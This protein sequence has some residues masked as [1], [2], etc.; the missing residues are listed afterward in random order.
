MIPRRTSIKTFFLRNMIFLAVTSILLW[1][2]VWVYSELSAFHSEILSL[3][4]NYINSQKEVLKKE[5]TNLTRYINS[6]EQNKEIELKRIIKDRTHIAHNIARNIY[7]ENRGKPSHE[8][9]KMI[10]DSLRPIRFNNGRCY[11][12]M[13]SMDGVE[14]LYPIKPELEGVNLID[15][16]DSQ[17]TSVIQ[18]EINVIEKH[19]E[20]FVTSYWTKPYHDRTLQFPQITFVKH[21]E[22]LN[23]YVGTGDY[24]DDFE[25]TLKT[26]V[27]NTI[28]NLQLPSGGHLFGSTFAGEPLLSNGNY[29][30]SGEESNHL[31]VTK[32]TTVF[33]QLIDTAMT[34]NGG[35][36]TFSF[37][38]PDGSG[39]DPMISYVHGIPIWNWLIGAEISLAAIEDTISK[40]KDLLKNNITQ[41]ILRS[42]LILS[43]LFI[44]IY[45]WSRHVAHRLSKNIQ[46]FSS[47]LHNAS[48]IQPGFVN[49]DIELEEF[50]RIALSAQKILEGRNQAVKELY[51]R[52][53]ELQITLNATTD[54]IWTWNLKTN[55]LTF[56]DRYSDMLGYKPGELP[57]HYSDWITLTHPDDRE[58]VNAMV[59]NVINEEE[60]YENEFR[61]RTK[62]GK[63][64]WISAKAKVAERNSEGE[65]L[66]IIGNH[67]D[68][69][70]RKEIEEEANNQRV[71]FE[72][73]FNTIPDAVVITDTQRVIQLANNGLHSVFG[74]SEEQLIGKTTEQLYANK[75]SYKLAGHHLFNENS[76]NT[77]DLYITAYRSN[78]GRSFPGE[79]FGAKLYDND[80]KWIGNLGIIRDISDRVRLE[81]EKEAEHR[82]L[83]SIFDG[84]DEVIYVSD[85]VTYELLY[86]NSAFTSKF[87]KYLHK[88]CYRVLQ[89]REEP[90]P[91]CT[92]HLILQKNIGTTHIWEHYN[93]L[94]ERWYRCI[95]RAINWPDDRV[96]RF[97]MALD[98]TEQKTAQ[99]IVAKTKDHLES[100]W[101]I[102]Q[103]ADH[104]IATICDLVL[105]E[106]QKMGESK[107]AFYGFL[108][109]EETVMNLHAWSQEAYRGC[110]VADKTKHFPIGNAGIWAEAVRKRKIV[111]VNTMT[112]GHTEQQKTPEGHVL[113]TR[114]MAVPLEINNKIVAIAC[115]ANKSTEYTLDDGQQ[116]L[117]FLSN[118]QILIDRKKA[119]L[120]LLQVR[121]SLEDAQRVAKIGSWEWNLQEDTVW[122]SDELYRIYGIEKEDGFENLENIL[123]RNVHPE[124]KAYLKQKINNSLVTGRFSADYKITNNGLQELSAEGE[125]L[126]DDS[127]KPE[128][129]IGTV[130]N[131]TTEKEFE[132]KMTQAHKMEAMGTLAGGIAHDFNNILAVII[133]Y[134]QM[135][136][137]D[138]PRGSTYRKDIQQISLAADRAKDLVS[139][140]LAFSRQS[141]VE[142]LPIMIKPIV[143]EAVKMLR[144]SIPS[145]I[146][147]TQNIQPTSS[148]ILADP[149]QIHQILINLCTNAYHAMEKTGGTLTISLQ[150]TAISSSQAQLLKIEP[151]EYTEL[152][153]TDTGNG[154]APENIDKIFEP[155][156]TTKEMGKGT[157]MGLSIIH[158]IINE[159]GGT[160][161]VD[162]QLEKGSAFHV[163]FPEVQA[164]SMPEIAQ[165]EVLQ[166]G[167][168]H[169]L[170]IDD[171]ILLAEMGK[172]ILERLGYRVTVYS[173]SLEALS[174]FLNNPNEFDLVI[175]DQTMPDMTGSVLAGR[176]LQARPDIPII[177][178]TGYSN[179]IDEH[180]AKAI[181]IKEFTFK[182][183]AQK[184]L[185]KLI[186][187]V[188]D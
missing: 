140:I 160:I 15:L 188:L 33:H 67:E 148:T 30:I 16:E 180:S 117:S 129:H 167:R 122:L 73:I 172:V 83:I 173:N 184:V 38:K 44:G 49:S 176:M 141:Q 14:Q 10:K 95:D 32:D 8:I 77:D 174:A 43:L 58:S 96:V 105:Q 68:I 90:C 88:K 92:N 45:L 123:L 27:L 94:T 124:D 155:Y 114:F 182:P 17:G 46:L 101:H 112:D 69:S 133:G 134:A 37:K 62:S 25:Q 63:Y 50:H 60:D 65:A 120:E 7:N 81:A 153:V 185:A 169:I 165:G 4:D 39:V 164:E 93:H 21:L 147:I 113:L 151:G 102:T 52:E 79:T 6:L 161:T 162:S 99:A 98:I 34:E 150:S 152:I 40:K 28:T 3:R 66:L 137:E 86:A 5:V 171:E 157:G 177:L 128:K 54:G 84:M 159:Y 108:N 130:K 125:I 13:V 57:S 20:G 12:F 156:F 85:P 144:S 72:T 135:A 111:I 132:R 168:E 51:E 47:S 126:Y 107:Y 106:I 2:M 78:T 91:F 87:G 36:V 48:V 75:H 143:K 119:K 31:R 163:F 76:S 97:E 170:F 158:G 118:V 136:L 186:R 146:S 18:E 139:Q 22:P 145:T 127:G 82:R 42:A 166:G 181:G 23:W 175:T 183:L 104:D 74:Y 29:V 1:C 56:S 187:K 9:E 55:E 178:C 131:V 100:L 103:M 89:N 64:I 53:K 59:H 116:I 19:G 179:L 110:K 11:F 35:Y 26:E 149:T 154:I 24:L 41:K 121:K 109:S 71:L 80:Q 115:V 138:A 70:K 61:F 142:R